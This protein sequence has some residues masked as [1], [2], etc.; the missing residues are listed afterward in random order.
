MIKI[1]PARFLSWNLDFLG[2]SA[3]F[4]CAIHCL[5]LPLLLSLGLF[6]G[7]TWLHHPLVE[8]GLIATAVLI[9]GPA[10]YRGY[11]QH[12]HP[13]PLWI[14]AFGFGLLALS[15]LSIADEHLLTAGGGLLIATAHW[16][17]W[18]YGKCEIRPG[19]RA[20]VEVQEDQPIEAITKKQF[21]VG[22]ILVVLLLLTF[23][24]SIKSTCVH[25]QKS[26][27]RSDVLELVWNR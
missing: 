19:A 25:P 21:D 24:L 22:K 16:F 1:K 2:F 4:L 13:R 27:E 23:L 20:A 15:R 3:S 12:G 8:W 26:L 14:A 9:A 11:G 18:K 10:F 6:G 5:A 7:L 17:N